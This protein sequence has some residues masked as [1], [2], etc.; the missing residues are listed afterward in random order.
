MSDN[1]NFTSMTKAAI[2]AWAADRGATISTDLTKDEMIVEAEKVATAPAE[3]PAPVPSVPSVPSVPNGLVGITITSAPES[4]FVTLRVNG[5]AKSFRVGAPIHIDADL[6][7]ALR[8]SGVE[9]TQE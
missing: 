2:A 6:L 9:F 1:P 5:K 7:P 4:P 8:D 3:D